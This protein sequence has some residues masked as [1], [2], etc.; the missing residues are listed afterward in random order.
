MVAIN[1]I[2]EQDELVPVWRESKG[3]TFPV[4]VGGDSEALFDDYGIVSTPLNFLLDSEGKV[5]RRLEGYIP[6]TEEEL[7]NQILE[8]MGLNSR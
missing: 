4:L 1:V 7:R 2:P 5:L 8:A 3:F 6:G